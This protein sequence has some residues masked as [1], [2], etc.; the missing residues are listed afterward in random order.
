MKNKMSLII[1]VDNKNVLYI[2]EM[3]EILKKYFTNME[4]TIETMMELTNNK[5][6]Y[7]I[8]CEMDLSEDNKYN[9]TFIGK[10]LVVKIISPVKKET[11]II[12]EEFCNLR[13]Q[14]YHDFIKRNN[15]K[16]ILKTKPYKLYTEHYKF[17]DDKE[18]VLDLTFGYNI[19]N[20]E[21]FCKFLRTEKAN[22]KN[23]FKFSDIRK[24]SNITSI[25]LIEVN[26]IHGSIIKSSIKEFVIQGKEAQN[27]DKIILDED[28]SFTYDLDEIDDLMYQTGILSLSEIKEALEKEEIEN[29]S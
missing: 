18:L 26:D 2:S 25:N 21:E 10:E 5:E 19:I 23:D 16:Y 29:N 9:F 4:T 7:D 11:L 27:F 17:F 22:L 15:I 12:K 20:H 6:F 8:K 3:P 28:L 1:E 24:Y 13:N 14:I